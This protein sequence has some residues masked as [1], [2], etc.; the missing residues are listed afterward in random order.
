MKNTTKDAMQ[1]G[2][3]F[4]GDAVGDVVSWFDV[5]NQSQVFPLDQL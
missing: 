4:S 2:S 3:D 5:K 1:L